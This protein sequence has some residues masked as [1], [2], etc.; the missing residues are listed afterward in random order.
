M[1]GIVFNSIFNQ[2]RPRSFR[3]PGHS[4]W[5]WTGRN[6]NSY[7]WSRR[8]SWLADSPGTSWACT[9]WCASWRAASAWTSW[10]RPRSGRGA[11]PSA[12]PNGT[13]GWPFD[14]RP[15]CRCRRRRACRPCVCACAGAGCSASWRSSCR[16]RR[17]A[18][19]GRRCSGS[20]CWGSTPLS[21]AR[22]TAT[23]TVRATRSSGWI[24]RNENRLVLAKF[25]SRGG[26]RRQRCIFA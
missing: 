26:G 12:W 9:P 4:N 11:R 3:A 5:H 20:C 21:G 14:W 7:S 1:I 25:E 15:W 22:A 13:W 23:R 8:V 16:R 18:W 2:R 19:C 17:R 24:L 6:C 10:S